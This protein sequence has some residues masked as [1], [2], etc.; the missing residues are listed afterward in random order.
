M[1][2][3]ADGDLGLDDPI[4]EQLTDL[5]CG[6]DL[7]GRLTPRQLLSHTS[8][9]PSS[10][11]ENIPAAATTSSRRYLAE[12]ARQAVP[13]CPP[14]T[15]F[16]YSNVGYLLLGHLIEMIT[17]LTWHEAV[18][19]TLLRPLGIE[20]AFIVGGNGSA[21]PIIPGLAVHPRTGRTQPVAQTV[22][23]A[24]AAVGALALSA[25][26]LAAFAALHLGTR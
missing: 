25:S 14:G 10:L 26:D 20:P 22:S 11:D 4:D 2:L 21:V 3:V 13:V 17:G 12:C 16:S 9:L 5:R 24:M 7:F 1:M 6:H 19:S 23:A 15:A 8:G 18:E